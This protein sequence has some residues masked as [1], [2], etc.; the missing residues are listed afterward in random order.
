MMHVCL[1]FRDRSRPVVCADILPT[2]CRHFAEPPGFAWLCLAL[3]GFVCD[4]YGVQSVC[5]ITHMRLGGHAL[6]KRKGVIGHMVY[7]EDFRLSSAY[8]PLNC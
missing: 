5:R 3:S 1:R 4:S 2:Y 7:V 6:P 8:L